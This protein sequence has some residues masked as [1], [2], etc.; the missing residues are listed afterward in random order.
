MAKAAVEGAIWDLYAKQKGMTL[1]KALDGEK[2]VIDV[3]IS[4]GIQPIIKNLLNKIQ[5]Y[6]QK[7]Y[8]RVKLKIKPGYDVEV[9][10]AVRHHFPD[11]SLM[12]DANG[13]Y[14][15]KDS[16]HLKKLDD[17]SLIMIEQPLAHHNI[18]DHATLQTYI[19]TPICLDEC[20]HSFEDARLA[21]RLGSC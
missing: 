11:L 1:A 9:L 3:G 15:I 18:L 17:F 7:G 4:L 2:L 21:I 14:T 10:R 19:K 13:A 20:I 16:D 12:V 6:V 5:L 8:K